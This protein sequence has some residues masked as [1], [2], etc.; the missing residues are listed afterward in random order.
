MVDLRF[1]EHESNVSPVGWRKQFQADDIARKIGAVAFQ[2]GPLR[3]SGFIGDHD[4][5]PI[6]CVSLSSRTAHRAVAWLA[7]L[8]TKS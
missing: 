2:P 6:G 5:A 4:G 1:S 7:H 3:S 8:V